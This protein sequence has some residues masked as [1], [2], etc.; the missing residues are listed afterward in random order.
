MKNLASGAFAFS[1]SMEL[2]ENMGQRL[3]FLS[4][5]PSP[6][7]LFISFFFVS[8]AW[9]ENLWYH[10][11]HVRFPLLFLASLLSGFL[12]CNREMWVNRRL[13]LMEYCIWIYG[14]FNTIVYV[15]DCTFS[16]GTW[17]LSTFLIMNFFAYL[18][19]W[20]ENCLHIYA[21]RKLIFQYM[22]NF[23]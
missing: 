20:T 17:Q 19:V 14:V 10:L 7:A 1:A 13:I 15:S 23:E 3:F 16:G 18:H 11:R 22:Y 4:F 5:L 2:A 6:F 12:L 9:T 21:F 8:L